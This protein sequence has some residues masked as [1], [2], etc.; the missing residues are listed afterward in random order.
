MRAIIV[1]QR[2]YRRYLARLEARRLQAWS[3]YESLEY[4]NEN[5]QSRVGCYSCSVVNSCQR[6][7]LNECVSEWV[8]EWV[9]VRWRDWMVDLLILVVY[10]IFCLFT[11]SFI[12]WVTSKGGEIF[13][14]WAG[15]G[16][17]PNIY[18]MGACFG[19][20]RSVWRDWI[21][22]GGW[23]SRI[24]KNKNWTLTN[25]LQQPSKHFTPSSGVMVQDSDTGR[26]LKLGSDSQYL[27]NFGANGPA[28]HSNL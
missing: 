27:F 3:I 24:L 21:C 5:D 26:M 20:I 2:W 4:A 11:C 22:R 1:I 28:L 15:G 10:F 18:E 19:D 8:G 23:K 12:Y 17:T 9:N 13:F 7:T 6:I 14:V 16:L 25:T